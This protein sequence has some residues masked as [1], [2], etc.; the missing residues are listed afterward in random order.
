[1]RRAIARNLDNGAGW[2]IPSFRNH[3]SI[4][5]Q[6]LIY[7]K[8]KSLYI[9]AIA[10]AGTS[11]SLHQLR[12]LSEALIFRRAIFALILV[13]AGT[14]LLLV[15]RGPL[16]NIG[17]NPPLTFSGARP[18]ESDA[19]MITLRAEAK[20]AMNALLATRLQRKARVESN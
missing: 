4:R 10:A 17:Q 5:W 16:L 20:S 1:M 6:R 2:G 7:E 11:P 18:I 15:S 13:L 19:K 14:A 9:G 8:W 3:I 12:S